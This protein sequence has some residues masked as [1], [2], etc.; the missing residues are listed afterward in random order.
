MDNQEFEDLEQTPQEPEV[1]RDQEYRD[2]FDNDFEAVMN[3]QIPDA[4]EE[5]VVRTRKRTARKKQESR[6]SGL[7]G[8]PHFLCTMILWGI[9]LFAGFTLAMVGW[10][11]ADDLLALT[12][13]DREISVTI[14]ETDDLETISKKLVNAGLV[15]YDWLFRL[16]G[17]KTHAM[18]KISEGTFVL[19]SMYDYHALVNGLRKSS[20][21]RTEV[22]V[23]IPE[24]YNCRELFALLERNEVCTA[25]ELGQAAINGDLGEYWFLEGL[26]REDEYCLE[27]YL[28]PDTYRFYTDDDPARVLRKLLNNFEDKFDET[29]QSRLELLNQNL[30][31]KLA[32]YGYSQEAIAQRKMTVH[33]IVIIASMIEKESAGRGESDLIA[34]VIYN[35]LCNPD[36]L[37]LNIDATIIYALGGTKDRLSLEDLNLD[38]PYNTYRVIGLPIGPISNPGL[39]SLRAAVMPEDTNYYYY[40]LDTDGTHYFSKTQAEHEAFLASLED[41]D[42]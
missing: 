37:Y 19:N 33:D 26:P 24:G 15:R 31:E 8:I 10:N 7:W 3:G 11:C 35:R 20:S 5:P 21:N 38:S 42:D 27:G 28:F 25:E 14:L 18:D 13:A 4:P 32:G 34:S 16:Y 23:M 40:A 22:E 17:E 12:K 1:F 41:A 6:D 36:Y 29:L 39:N 30:A 9:V 2:T